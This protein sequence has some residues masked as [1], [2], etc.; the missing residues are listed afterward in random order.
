MMVMSAVTRPNIVVLGSI[1][2]DLVVRGP[3]LPRPG[4]TVL[5]GSFYEAPG[6]KGANQAVAAARAAGPDGPRVTFLAAVG[7]DAYGRAARERLRGEGIDC[8]FVKTVPGHTTGVAVILVDQQGENLI[9]V[10]SG[11]NSHL[12]PRDIDDVP[13]AAFQEAAV[14]LASLESPLATVTRGLERAKAAG[15]ATILNPAPATPEAASPSL[16]TLVDVLTPNESEAALLAGREVTSDEDLR[17]IAAA[18]RAA[19]CRSVV[20]TLG[21]RGCLVVGD[22][23]VAVPGHAV[24]AVDTTAAGDAFSGALAVALAEG[25]PLLEAARFANRAAAISVTRQGAQPSLPLRREID[26]VSASLARD[27]DD[28]GK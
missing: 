9:S 21:R 13:L 24:T 12:L 1:N 18:W 15:A 4:E 10:A 3:R 17:S 20:F 8:R 23:T 28:A 22:G 11:A 7:E 6:G 14:F 27:D 26:S 5:G 16:L 2:I 25:K 19:G